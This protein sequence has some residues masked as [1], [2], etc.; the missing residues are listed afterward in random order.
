MVGVA[1]A[2]GARRLGGYARGSK[3]SVCGNDFG[4]RG[5]EHFVVGE[6]R[7]HHRFVVGDGGGKFVHTVVQNFHEGRKL[8]R[9]CF[10]LVPGSMASRMVAGRVGYAVDGRGGVGG[11][12]VVATVFARDAGNAFE[13]K[14]GDHEDL[15]PL[16]PIFFYIQ[17]SIPVRAFVKE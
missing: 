12:K 8:G 6:K 10:V 16:C 2:G 4:V 11:S 1:C 14:L 15:L 5:G 13:G 3:G 7:V 17:V 9:D